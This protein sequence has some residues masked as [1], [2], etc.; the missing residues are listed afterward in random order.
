[1]GKKQKN[2]ITSV[3]EN[4]PMPDAMLSFQGPIDMQI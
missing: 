4:G 3:K 1:V 2:K